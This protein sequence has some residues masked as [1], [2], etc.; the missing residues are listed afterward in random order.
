M[1]NHR[2]TG[3]TPFIVAIAIVMLVCSAC[4][5][6]GDHRGIESLGSR[7]STK[8]PGTIDFQSKTYE[9]TGKILKTEKVVP[10]DFT[11]LGTI[12]SDDVPSLDGLEASNG[13]VFAIS[14]VDKDTAVAVRFESMD[15][16]IFYYFEY[17]A[18]K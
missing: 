11:F 18:S 5:A 15:G 14:G 13:R 9:A 6:S 3:P 10:D 17:R 2:R 16:R 8:I 7:I 4:T 1:V 12:E